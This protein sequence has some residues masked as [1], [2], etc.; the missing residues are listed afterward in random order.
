MNEAHEQG[1]QLLNVGNYTRLVDTATGEL[2]KG[3][4]YAQCDHWCR[5]TD[6]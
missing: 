6:F 3:S 5:Y 1:L 4:C 2:D